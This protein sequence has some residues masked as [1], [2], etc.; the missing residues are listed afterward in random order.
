MTWEVRLDA[1]LLDAAK[2]GVGEDDIDAISSSIADVW[3]GERVVV[4]NEAGIL[5]PMQE[6]VGRAEH[7]RQRLLLDRSERLL[8]APLIVRR[9]HVVL[10][11]VPYGAGDE[12]A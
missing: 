11:H 2:W 10:P 12:P 7:V 8:Q 6:H 1:R 4:S 5:D 3:T 9:L